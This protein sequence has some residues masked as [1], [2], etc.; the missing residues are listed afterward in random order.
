MEKSTFVGIVFWGGLLVAYVLISLGSS[1]S[2]KALKKGK[3]ELYIPD[4]IISED[5]N[6]YT[7]RKP[8]KTLDTI[9]SIF[10]Y[11]GVIIGF[12]AIAQAVMYIITGIF[13]Y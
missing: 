3:D 9:S 6:I 8:D 10:T 13:A 5:S 7:Y 4:E 11:L 2:K 12:V 1:I